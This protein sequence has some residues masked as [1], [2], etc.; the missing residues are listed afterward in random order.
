MSGNWSKDPDGGAPEPAD[1]PAIGQHGTF[2]DTPLADVHDPALGGGPDDPLLDGDPDSPLSQDEEDEIT[3]D[4]VL[5]DDDEDPG[6][7]A[8]DNDPPEEAC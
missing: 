8:L 7:L 4:P 6:D 2:E 1:F 5:G 3:N